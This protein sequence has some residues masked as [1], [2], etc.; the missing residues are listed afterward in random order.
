VVC[1]N[2]LVALGVLETFRH[3]GIRVPEDV[4]VTGYDDSIFA[5]V[6][7]SPLTSVRQPL[8]LLGQEAVRLLITAIECPGRSH[9]DMRMLPELIVRESSARRVGAAI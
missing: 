5:E 4:A 2:D 1:A 9:R 7:D 6:A 3:V 8:K